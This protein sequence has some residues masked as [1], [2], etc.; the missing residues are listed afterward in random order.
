M[1]HDSRGTL[2]LPSTLFSSRADPGQA[3]PRVLAKWSELSLEARVR[4]LRVGAEPLLSGRTQPVL[5]CLNEQRAVG[6]QEVEELPRSCASAYVAFR[7]GPEVAERFSS[8][9]GREVV[10]V[11]WTLAPWSLPGHVALSVSA[12]AEYVFYDAGERVLC[13]AKELLAR[14]LAEVKADEL[15]MKNARLPGGD[16]ETVAF[17]DLRKILVYASGEDLAGLRYQHPF[18]ERTGQVVLGGPSALEEGTGLVHV[19]PGLG[20]GD[21]EVD[22][23]LG[24][25]LDS[26]VDPDGRYD[27]SVG[28]RLQ[29]VKVLEA[30]P[31]VLE[32][33]TERRALLNTKKDTVER[34]LPHCRHCHQ[35]VLRKGDAGV[36]P[37]LAWYGGDVLRLWAVSREPQSDV[38]LS[39]AI[40]EALSQ[41]IEKL[42]H[43]LA[44]ALGHL[45]GFEPSRDA[46]PA[47]HLLSLDAWARG[48]LSEVVARVLQAYEAGAFHRV[49]SEVLE[50]CTVE[51]SASY[52]AIVEDRLLTAKAS[53]R[54]RRSAQTVLFEVT[55]ALLRLLA[56]ILSFTAEE[57][58]QQL[59]G[60]PV[61]SVFLMDMPRSMGPMDPELAERYSRLLAMRGAVQPLIEETRRDAQLDSSL[62]T[63]VVLAAAGEAR[64][65][66]FAH[67]DELPSLFHVSQVELVE[68]PE[69]KMRPLALSKAWPGV[70]L[71]A[72]ALPAWGAKCPRCGGFAEEVA[73]GRD[74]CPK[75]RAALS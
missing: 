47:S 48:R 72:E 21:A 1:S 3:E 2:N 50:Y 23:K 16:V 57:A 14:V 56:P 32:L 73:Q 31:A 11:T 68:E 37:F 7:A 25:E 52:F 18:L 71:A 66:L 38:P 39:D 10:F 6:A 58:W 30:D 22:P 62:G 33:L 41:D 26:L 36:K 75:C 46:V 63:R 64:A 51:L 27:A 34:S 12:D 49:Y 15:V 67:I 43:T 19:A 55:T 65:F 54:E 29:G 17:D 70:E 40:L 5:W 9:K 45:S 53:G 42:R 13:V 44:F 24:L 69:P 20:Q 60:R 28:A 61:E 35:L 59:P 74:V 4:E 8:L